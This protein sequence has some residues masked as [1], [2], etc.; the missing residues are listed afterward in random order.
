MTIN[1]FIEKFAEA[2]EYENETPLTPDTK[3]R[4]L[5]IWDSL[6]HLNLILMLDEEYNTQIEQAELK[7]LL[8]LGDLFN[9]INK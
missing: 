5:D 6:A 4:D 1:D 2:V 9:F 7:N 8:T 3:F